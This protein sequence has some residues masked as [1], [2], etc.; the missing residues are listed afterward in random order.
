MR[1]PWPVVYT[2]KHARTEAESVQQARLTAKEARGK[3]SRVKAWQQVDKIK[4]KE[5]LKRKPEINK[6]LSLESTTK[7]LKA[8]RRMEKAFIDDYINKIKLFKR[9][10]REQYDGEYTFTVR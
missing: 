9:D 1:I 4:T 2:K 6:G 5:A 8:K 7:L 3:H 10:E